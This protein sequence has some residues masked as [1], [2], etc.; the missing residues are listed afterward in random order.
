MFDL[1]TLR[2]VVLV[3]LGPVVVGAPL[4]WLVNGRQPLD[5]NDWV[6]APFL[7][8][9]ALVLALQMQV[10]L[11]LRVGLTTPAMWAVVLVLWLWLAWSG[12]FTA[13]LRGIPWAAF[14]VALVVYLVQGLGLFQ[15]G[16]RYYMGR[17]W[18]D[19]SWYFA[20]GEYLRDYPYSTE[21]EAVG[22]QPHLLLG[23]IFRI[24]ER[25]GQSVLLAFFSATAQ[26]D[27]KVMFMPVSLLGPALT[28]L[29]VYAVCTRF[30]MPGWLSSVAGA[31]AGL[32]PGVTLV[33]LENFLSQAL[34]VPYLILCPVVLHEVAARPTWPRILNVA[35]LF[36]GTLATFPEMSLLLLGPTVLLLGIVALPSAPRWRVAL[37][38]L[39]IVGLPVAFNFTITTLPR[40][41]GAEAARGII[42]GTDERVVS[43]L[44]PTLVV[45]T[46]VHPWGL[47]V[48]GLSRLWFG[49]LVTAP[50]W[51]QAP[52]VVPTFAVVIVALG[53]AGLV[54]VCV[55]RLKEG[56]ATWLDPERRGQLAFGVTVLAL[57]S[58]PLVA[59]PLAPTLPYHYYKL[60]LCVCPL[61]PAGLALASWPL[62]AA[63]AL[64]L[65]V[66]LAV[67]A[68]GTFHM[69]QHSTSYGP[70]TEAELTGWGGWD[71]HPARQLAGPDM[72]E[73][74]DY[75]ESLRG[76]PL[77]IVCPDPLRN[78]WL[79]YYS[80][81]NPRW[82][83]NPVITG[84]ADDDG[85]C[86]L[87][88]RPPAR[89]VVDLGAMPDDVLV[90]SARAGGGFELERPASSELVW[91]NE[92]FQVWRP[93]DRCWAVPARLVT[94]DGTEEG[95][96]GPTF[97]MTPAPT[98]V[99]VVAASAGRVAL[100]ARFAGDPELPRLKVQTSAEYAAE[101]M[102]P[103][104]EGT[105]FVPV[106][107]G[108]S[109][110]M[111]T[112]KWASAVLR[113]HEG[114]PSLGVVGLRLQWAGTP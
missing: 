14:G 12:H 16:A 102:P 20:M 85:N 114:V 96:L 89:P 108:R 98:T 28:A 63:G 4:R 46:N 97:S 36:G 92:S 56:R 22:D 6:Q 67:A 83:A 86:R 109:S 69:V 5:R 99:E 26:T 95:R 77:L 62:R 24:A 72:C 64:P 30:G 113:E 9:A 82:L 111:L 52:L 34:A 3:L 37:G 110:I 107:A 112:P 29:A 44:D 27:S 7:G 87:D 88:I 60:I 35:V 71:R 1:L 65:A 53:F 45:M 18:W 8:L 51:E 75:L 39:L 49:D 58:L 42:K 23:Q 94:Q 41:A 50:H 38:G 79:S 70:P 80:R 74:Q 59:L 17:G 91:E 31:T 105:L 19:Q 57:A 54:S 33:T 93:R 66:P 11:D 73:V 81:Y 15:V 25:F 100:T 21:L 43:N 13:S 68:A 48:E 55:R 10:Y 90:V 47:R 103:D 40:L 101:F 2:C 61:L 76:T 106:P 104:G 84:A 32:M 78:T